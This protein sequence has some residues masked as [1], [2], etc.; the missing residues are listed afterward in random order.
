[1]QPDA[2][3]QALHTPSVFGADVTDVKILQTHISYVVLTGK[4]AY[5]IKKAVDFGFLDYSTLEK[6]KHFCQQEVTLNRRL[7]PEIY[8]DVVAFTKKGETLDLNGSG[9][10]V[11]YAVKMKQ[12]PQKDI[13]TQ[14]LQKG[15][16]NQNHIDMLLSV[17]IVC[18]MLF[19]AS[20]PLLCHFLPA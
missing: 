11:E 5:K 2:F 1:M 6:R 13:M 8:L 14:Q 4:Y 10:I 20:L 3:F 17:L 16:I 18:N 9:E 7:C 15:S 12:F 19:M